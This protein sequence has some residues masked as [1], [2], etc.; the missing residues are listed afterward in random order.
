MEIAFNLVSKQQF[1]VMSLYIY[2]DAVGGKA[3][4]GLFAHFLLMNSEFSVCESYR[5]DNRATR[6]SLS[7]QVSK[8]PQFALIYSSKP[9]PF[10]IRVSKMI[11]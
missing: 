9:D 10:Q 7:H 11:L 6:S 1:A 5:C 2:Q 8:V 3:R 4:E